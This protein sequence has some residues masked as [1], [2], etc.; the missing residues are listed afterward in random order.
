MAESMLANLLK[1]PQQVREEQEAKLRQQ[2]MQRASAIKAPQG[3]S[4][5]LPG[6]FASLARQQTV[7]G[8]NDMNLM[9]RGLGQG[10]GGLLQAAGAPEEL[11]RA[12]G[13]FGTTP[14]ERRAAQTQQMLKGITPGDA[15]SL[16]AAAKQLADS[17]R[18]QE[19]MALATRA[20]QIEQLELTKTK[21]ET[22]KLAA[23]A[24]LAATKN[25][26]PTSR[27]V[28]RGDEIVTEEYN[29]ET[30]KW[31]QVGEAKRWEA[32]VPTTRTRIDQ[33]E[34]VVEQYDPETQLWTEVSRGARYQ[35]TSPGEISAA[36]YK[37]SQE[38]I[39]DKESMKY[40]IESYAKNN[41]A[42]DSARKTFATTDQMRQLVNSGILTGALADVALP[43]AKLLV[44]IGAID[45]ET[46][47]N[48]E[49]FV[50]TAA[51]Q[52]VALLAS[53]VFGTAQS[54]TDNDRKFAEG[55]AGGDITLTEE[56]IR[57]LVDMNEYY[58]TLAFE[59]QQRG[60]NQAQKAFPESK[61]VKAVFQP[62][63]YN[64]QQFTVPIEGGGTKIVFWNESI[65]KFEDQ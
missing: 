20:M 7:A 2:A 25:K 12:V 61:R 59:Q 24:K 38:S 10:A 52:T 8:A 51:R 57:T 30:Q 18:P 60:V 47:E 43:A 28:K 9:A 37:G 39:V 33:D 14:E 42:V 49:K 29:P 62:M 41:Q 6:I 32:T 27:E 45:S 16:R 4:T 36:V 35:P 15:K 63:Y 26:P 3:A 44:R 17:G 13:Q 5:A 48:T 34:K 40:Y 19:A 65:Q 58:A 50:K 21:T 22:A 46:V 23:E 55:M 1:T 64:G 53:G 54:I 11:S 31:T 56:T